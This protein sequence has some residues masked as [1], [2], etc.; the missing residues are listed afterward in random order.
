M[1]RVKRTAGAALVA[2]A[3]L[4]AAV[5]LATPA[6][7]AESDSGRVAVEQ[8]AP[9]ANDARTKGTGE[10]TF[11]LEYAKGYELTPGME[12]GCFTGTFA[13]ANGYVACVGILKFEG[14]RWR[15]AAAACGL[16]KL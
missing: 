1:T 3:A 2:I 8:S 14:V 15:H 12:W 13:G 6:Q 9:G 7:A 16:A 10:C 4:L 11:Y 5:F